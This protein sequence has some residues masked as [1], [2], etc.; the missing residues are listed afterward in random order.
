MKEKQISINLK[1]GICDDDICMASDIEK[2]VM[3]YCKMKSLGFDIDTYYSGDRIV[4]DL[5]E[6]VYFDILFLD[7]EMKKMDGVMVGHYIREQLHNDSML[8][9]YISSY[10][11]Y[12]MELFQIRPMDFLVKPISPQRMYEVLDI[13]V[14]LLNRKEISFSYKQGRNF[15]K[16]LVKEI[17]YFR[18]KDRE[19]EMITTN[20]VICFYEVLGNIYQVLKDHGFFFIHKSYLVNYDYVDEFYYDRLIMVNGECLK[21][22]QGRRKDVRKY[23]IEMLCGEMNDGN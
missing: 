17:I 14:R 19:V 4:K 20:G 8:I 6:R 5:E 2:F 22:A 9:I 12:A 15:N 11:Q 21:I 18:A 10:T 23:Q 7:I 16:I 3:T 13:A 1:I